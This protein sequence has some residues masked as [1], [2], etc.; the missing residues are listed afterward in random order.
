M[1]CSWWCWQ[2]GWTEVLTGIDRDDG[3][4]ENEVE[5]IFLMVRGVGDYGIL[6][7]YTLV[8]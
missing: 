1:I 8:I 3:I 5:R 6:R 4:E 2:T 7:E